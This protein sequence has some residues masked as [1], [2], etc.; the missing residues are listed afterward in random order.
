MESFRHS[1]TF[2]TAMRKSQNYNAIPA[3]RPK[4]GPMLKPRKRFDFP[5]MLMA[6]PG[7]QEKYQE[8]PPG[9]QGNHLQPLSKPYES[10]GQKVL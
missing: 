7:C 10:V 2:W 5:H 6:I 3:W 1:G 9:L 8:Q 4:E